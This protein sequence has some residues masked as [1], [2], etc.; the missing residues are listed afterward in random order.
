MRE[1]MIF[2]GVIGLLV[3]WAFFVGKRIESDKCKLDN[4]RAAE[5]QEVDVSRETIR[6]M[7]HSNLGLSSRLRPY[8]RGDS[9]PVV[10]TPTGPDNP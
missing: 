8:T 2:I 6:A 5:R 1:V 9:G 7:G 3:T 10:F 4:Q